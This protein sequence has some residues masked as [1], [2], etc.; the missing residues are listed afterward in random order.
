MCGTTALL[1]S[2]PPTIKHWES[3]RNSRQS[4][5]RLSIYDLSL[6]FRQICSHHLHK[7]T[8][9][10]AWWHM[11]LTHRPFQH[12]QQIKPSHTHENKICVKLYVHDNVCVGSLVGHILYT[13]TH[14]TKC[15]KIHSYART[16]TLT[17]TLSKAN[18][19]SALSLL[20]K[21]IIWYS[22]ATHIFKPIQTYLKYTKPQFKSS[23]LQMCHTHEN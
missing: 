2:L 15:T 9:K 18:N 21:H 14:A 7:H 23:N 3:E 10:N 19:F 6:T 16:Q 8:Y 22:F 11:H 1:G 4:E 17:P 12:C 13:P 20:Q 5:S